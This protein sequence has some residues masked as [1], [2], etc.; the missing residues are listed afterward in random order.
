MTIKVIPAALLAAMGLWGQPPT[1]G[2]RDRVLSALHGSNK[3]FRDAVAGLSSTQWTFKPAPDRWSIAQIAEHL[4]LVENGVFQLITVQGLQSQ[5][6]PANRSD[7]ARKDELIIKA[8][9]DRTQKLQA[10][11]KYQPSGQFKSG[12]EAAG[13]F[14]AASAKCAAYI[15]ETQDSLRG[16]LLTHPAY[17]PLDLHQWFLL[18]AGHA[19]RH[20][21]QIL[22]V[23]ADPNYP[24]R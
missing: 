23:K 5:D 12:E 13:A 9:P 16:H 19:E 11:E 18:L 2:E 14:L 17:G 7:Q 15:R 10:P 24:K 4:A 22:E 6:T 8:L 1:Q 3:M 20:T 21:A